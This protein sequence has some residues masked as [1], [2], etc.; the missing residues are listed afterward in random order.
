MSV[1]FLFSS[2]TGF[3]LIEF[4]RP[5]IILQRCFGL[6][7]MERMKF[8]VEKLKKKCIKREQILLFFSFRKAQEDPNNTK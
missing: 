7:E 8:H 5:E 4:K 6:T 1:S 2:D 3:M